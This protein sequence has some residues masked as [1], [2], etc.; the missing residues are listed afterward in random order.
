MIR[1]AGGTP[2]VIVLLH[3]GPPDVSDLLASP[4]VGAILSA[5]MPGQHGGL[6]LADV[7]LGKAAPSGVAGSRCGLESCLN[8]VAASALCRLPGR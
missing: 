1:G 3:G 6:A 4:A 7:L 2:I 8:P 5:C